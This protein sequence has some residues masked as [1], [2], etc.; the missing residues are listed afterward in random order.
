MVLESV[1][2]QF[3]EDAPMCVMARMVLEKFLDAQEIDQLFDD[4]AQEQYTRD[5]LFSACVDLMALVVFRIQKSVSKAY[6]KLRDRC[7]VTLKSVY[8]KLAHVETRVCQALLRYSRN[9][10]HNFF[11]RMN[12]QPKRQLEGYALRVVD[13]NHLAATDRRLAQQRGQSSAFLPGQSLCVYDPDYDLIV[14]MIGCEDAY[15]QERSL[16]ADVYELVEPDQVWVADRGLC[17]SDFLTQVAHKSA[18]FV[19][20]QHA[21]LSICSTQTF[22][23]STQTEKGS[24]SERDVEITVAGE[25]VL[26][27]RQVRIVLDERTSDHEREITVLTN[28]PV[29]VSRDAVADVYLGRWSIETTFQTLTVS[30][31]CEV[32]TLAYPKA[33]LFGFTMAL[34]MYNVLAVVKGSLA[35]AHRQVDVQN[36]LSWSNVADEVAGVYRG[37]MIALPLVFWARFGQMTDEQ[38]VRELLG[39]AQ[40]VNPNNYKKARRKPKKKVKK[41]YNGIPH[42]STARVLEER[43]T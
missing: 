6:D 35:C 29:G 26:A 22:G 13:G 9:K 34:M 21:N 33:A 39:V 38:F 42:R 4:N 30:L 11:R 40:R 41:I 27:A 24:V 17:T 16:L 3:V 15:T 43:Y 32:K 14:D 36:E 7:R 5:L 8:E 20:R 28:L 19:I 10:A 12:F 31:R 37:M 25:V 23:P 18:Y 2:E 1:F